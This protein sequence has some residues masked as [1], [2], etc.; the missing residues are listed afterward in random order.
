MHLR[1]RNVLGF[2]ASDIR[3]SGSYNTM[4]LLTEHHHL[5]SLHEYLTHSALPDQAV[6]TR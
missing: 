5:G 4:L 1:H 2:I 6:A 3:G